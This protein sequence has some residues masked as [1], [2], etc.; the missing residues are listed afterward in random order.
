MRVEGRVQAERM[1]R[2]ARDKQGWRGWVV[3]MP[4]QRKGTENPLW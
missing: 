1:R 2:E 4:F 3:G